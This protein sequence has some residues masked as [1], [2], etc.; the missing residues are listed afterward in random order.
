MDTLTSTPAGEA[1]ADF[2]HDG[3]AGR[4]ARILDAAE[5][6]FVRAGFHRTTMQDVAAEAAMSPATSTAISARR[7]RSSPALPSATGRG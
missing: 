2:G 3:G 7:T 6:C 5:R 4:R 1:P